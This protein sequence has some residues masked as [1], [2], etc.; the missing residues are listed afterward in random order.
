MGFIFYKDF[1]KSKSINSDPSAYL[2]DCITGAIDKKNKNG[3]ESDTDF[4]ITIPLQV[5]LN[6]ATSKLIDPIRFNNELI[7]VR[8]ALYLDLG[9]LF[10]K[11][12]LNIT[13]FHPDEQYTILVNEV[14]I[15]Q[16]RLY[17]EHYLVMESAATLSVLGI[18]SVADKPFGSDQPAFWVPFRYKRDLDIARVEYMGHSRLLAHHISII[19]KKHAAE[20]IGLQETKYLMG[21]V[22]EKYP[23]LVQ[24]L[25]KVLTISQITNVLQR[26]VEEEVSIKNLKLIFHY[27]IEWG[28]RE[29]DII[30]LTEYVRIELKRYITYHYSAGQNML[31]VYM[32]DRQLEEDIRNAIRKTS[33]SSYLVLGPEKNKQII[34]ALKQ[35]IGETN[36]HLPK[37]VLL[38]SMDIRR[39]VKKLVEPEFQ[40]LPVLSYQ[41][42]TPDISIQPLG[43]IQ[44]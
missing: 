21:K 5:D 31:A 18:D 10:P 27:L 4:A 1:K 33:G 14:P 28:Q 22:E 26:L 36:G 38:T 12:N 2:L 15:C 23:D 19:L 13:D 25:Q 9:I 29:K 34:D 7:R 17:R 30:L 11:V 24:E 32:L 37:P 3:R 8:R 20:F 44:L 39:Y 42:L 6:S 40:H 35:E 41:E 16:G 43:R